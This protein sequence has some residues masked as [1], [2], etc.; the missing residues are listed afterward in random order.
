MQE[1]LEKNYKIAVGGLIVVIMVLAAAFASSRNTAAKEIAGLN[2]EKTSI[3]ATAASQEKELEETRNRLAELERSARQAK[4]EIASLTES[5]GKL[6]ENIISLTDTLTSA[7]KRIASLQD[8]VDIRRKAMANMR[9]DIADLKRK[10][11]ESIKEIGSLKEENAVLNE[12]KTSLDAAVKSSE[13]KLEET[14][15]RVT[16][17]E[18]VSLPRAENAL[19][20]SSGSL[21]AVM[22]KLSDLA[23]F[24]AIT[25]ELK[26]ALPSFSGIVGNKENFDSFVSSLDAFED[27]FGAVRDVAVLIEMN[28]R[29]EIYASFSAD[30]VKLGEFMS[31]NSSLYNFDPW[32]PGFAEGGAGYKLRPA[33]D[34]AV[35]D[36]WFYVLVRPA[37]ASSLVFAATKEDAVSHMADAYDGVSPRFES[38]RHTTGENFV[39]VKLRD[40]ITYRDIGQ[41]MWNMPA[42][43]NLWNSTPD[44]IFWSVVEK[45]WAH[46]GSDIVSETYSDMFERNPEMLPPRPENAWKSVIYGDGNLA[47]YVSADFGML[48]NMLMPGAT[49]LTPEI[50]ALLDT[51][52]ALPV[53][54]KE[55]FKDLLRG[56]RLSFICVEKDGRVSTAY[57]AIETNV[58][59]AADALYKLAGLGFLMLPGGKISNI[60][61]WNSAMSAPLPLPLEGVTWPIPNLVTAGKPGVFLVGLGNAEDFGKTLDVQAECLDYMDTK[62]IGEMFISRKIFDVAINYVNFF[63][64]LKPSYISPEDMK[65]KDLAIGVMSEIRDFFV[66]LGGSV[67]PSGRGY[68]KLTLPEGKDPIKS[69]FA[70][71]LLPCIELA[72]LETNDATDNAG[73]ADIIIGKEQSQTSQQNYAADGAEATRIINDLRIL[74]SA[75]LTYY[76]D[77]LEWPTQA[78][79][80]ELDKYTDRPIVSDDRYEQVM[81]GGEYEDGSGVKRTN[82]GVKLRPEYNGAPG[83]REEL[84]GKAED[85]GLLESADSSVNFYSGSS[86]EVYMNMR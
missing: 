82:I 60:A 70:A 41:S 81:I 74:K 12:T 42:L 66:F 27:F 45:S 39:Q 86:L 77:N 25:S 26:E 3:E 58:P 1:W 55:D 10:A 31:R 67:K 15:T 54:S 40:G 51:Y 16:E 53:I 22:L 7:D 56:G 71:V 44:K 20:A 49:S 75:A 52:A 65:V 50:L 80:K 18:K 9:E 2:K 21:G 72:L 85:T 48:L 34:K 14:R 4:S 47:Y 84:A 28:G 6:N 64:D 35:D 61:G 57:A 63:A 73:A 37:G 76:G 8:S 11:R 29:S 59:N 38:E 62:N 5:N 19:P 32:Y 30:A 17:L 68:V 33:G 69:L 43:A 46:E 36:V 23:P 83:I 13:K 24:G 78:D 79:V